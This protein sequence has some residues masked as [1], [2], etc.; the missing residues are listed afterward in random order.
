MKKTFSDS[1]DMMIKIY[2]YVLNNQVNFIWIC[3]G[4]GVEILNMSI[5]FFD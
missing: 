1:I 3:G 5:L 4:S 2:N